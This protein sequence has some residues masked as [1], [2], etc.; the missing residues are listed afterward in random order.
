MK[1]PKSPSSKYRIIKGKYKSK[2]KSK[3]IQTE[4]WKRIRRDIY[5]NSNGLCSACG[6]I[7]IPGHAYLNYN[8]DHIRPIHHKTATKQEVYDRSNLQLLCSFCHLQKTNR[9]SGNA[10]PQLFYVDPLTGEISDSPHEHD[11]SLSR[12]LKIQYLQDLVA[13]GKIVL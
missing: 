1:Q 8:I 10:Q 3:Y 4:E 9:E 12:S 2:P 6:T 11:L 13:S 5:A 7:T